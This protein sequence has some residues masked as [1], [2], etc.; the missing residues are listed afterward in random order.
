MSPSFL[1]AKAASLYLR[2]TPELLF[3]Y[4]RYGAKGR[5]GKRLPTVDGTTTTRFSKSDLDAYDVYL[6]EPWPSPE[7]KRAEIPTG[8]RDYLKIEAGGM[9]ARC[10]AGSPLED[11]HIIDWETSRSNHHHNLVRLC[12]NCHG[13]YDTGAISRSEID[14]IKASVVERVQRR[15]TGARRTQW[16]ISAAPPVAPHL[17]GR[18]SELSE[19]V[20]A[21][22]SGESLIILGVGGIGKTQLALHA[23]RTAIRERPIV[24]VSIDTF[25]DTSTV[26][27]SF[28]A[29]AQAAGIE[30]EDGKPLLDEA[31]ACVVFDGIERLGRGQDE[32]SDLL[33]RLLSDY[34]DTIILVTSQVR[35]PWLQFGLELRLGP[36]SD[37]ASVNLLGVGAD[38]VGHETSIKKLLEFADGHPL[39][40][41]ILTAVV[42]HYGGTDAAVERLERLG[43][44]AVSMPRRQQ[45]SERTSLLHCLNLA[46]SLLS[47]TERRLLWLVASSPGGLRPGLHDLDNLIGSQAIA[48]AAELRA[49][50]LVDLFIDDVFE[51][52]SP[53]R[54]VIFMLSPIRAFVNFTSQQEPLDGMMNLK[55]AFCRS[56]TLLV[57]FIQ[58]ELLQGN[59]IDA[60]KALMERELPNAM[61]AFEIAADHA[62]VHR[63]F[64]DVVV[65]LANATMMTFF[66]SG[67]FEAGQSL[68]RRASDTAARYGPLTD[69]IQFL[70]QMQVLAERAFNREAAS[71]ALAEAERIG[72]DAEGVDLGL[73]RL[74]QASA[75]EFGGDYDQAIRLAQEAVDMLQRLN[76]PKGEWVWSGRFQL[77]RALEFGGRPAEALP[78]YHNALEAVEEYGDPVNKGSILHHIGNC[79]AYA[80]RWQAAVDAYCEAAEQFVQLEAVEFISNAL[81]EAGVIIHRVNLLNGLPNRQ[82]IAAGLDDIVDQIALLLSKEQFGGRNPRVTFRKFG[83]VVSLALHTGNR[84]LLGNVADGMYWRFIEPLEQQVDNRP[85]WLKVLIFHIQW[86]IRFLQFL[87]F[88]IQREGPLSSGELFIL[89]QLAGRAFVMDLMTVS[90]WLASYLQR[91]CRMADTASAD[92]LWMMRLDENEATF[93]QAREQ[94]AAEGVDLGWIDNG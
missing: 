43:A 56:E 60:G 69:A 64:L 26:S 7:G 33:E 24:W 89:A 59:A 13:M 11:A 5:N 42:R 22:R 28:L 84:D 71:F 90:D 3:Y 12:K 82:I 79:E 91:R 66:T 65:A 35:I 34:T 80:G 30:L 37:G 86:M 15:I 81:G 76:G 19:A 14:R 25:G 54:I 74:L 38:D 6:Q 40:L 52:G 47:V 29:Q 88:G 61:A 73:L 27:D 67:R 39:T 72:A 83:G 62:E 41:R 51:N 21:L 85:D 4:V 94:A 58:G 16:P 63:D 32:V 36:I 93:H 92:A 2:I 70:L 9:C 31:R 45:H 46:Y 1:D 8:V 68:M 78:L 53:A 18:E 44:E 87:C 48:A 17:L 55:I 57:R 50:N 23:L 77:A 10:G 20:D 75:A 49:W